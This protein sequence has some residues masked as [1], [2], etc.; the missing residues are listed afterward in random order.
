MEEKLFILSALTEGVRTSMGKSSFVFFM[1]RAQN[2]ILFIGIIELLTNCA[3]MMKI[4][5]C[6]KKAQF[7]RGSSMLV[8]DIHCSWKGLAVP[9]NESA[10]LPPQGKNAVFHVAVP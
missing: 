10:S 2:E 9:T 7:H 6:K 8:K 1:S 3:F 4:G 5:R